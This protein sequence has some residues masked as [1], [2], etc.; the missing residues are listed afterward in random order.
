MVTRWE[1]SSSEQLVARSAS[2]SSTTSADSSAANPAIALLASSRFPLQHRGGGGAGHRNSSP[3][4]WRSKQ[5]YQQ[6]ESKN[7]K[8]MPI[9][10][11]RF[12]PSSSSNGN[13]DRQRFPGSCVAAGSAPVLKE[14]FDLNLRGG[15]RLCGLRASAYSPLE[16]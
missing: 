9:L 3:A 8:T 15:R 4:P 14:Q 1:A 2:S 12:M 5:L 7:S 11:K 16:S 10:A 13:V 6:S